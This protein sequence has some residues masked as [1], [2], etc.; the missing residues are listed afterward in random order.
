M[1]KLLERHLRKTA[2]ALIAISFTLSTLMLIA[3]VGIWN[4]S[5]ETTDSAGRRMGFNDPLSMEHYGIILSNFSIQKLLAPAYAY[6]WLLLIMHLVGA[7]L[8]LRYEGL[9]RVPIRVFFALQSL[10]FPVGWL[11]FFYLP[12]V[13][14][15]LLNGTFDQEAMTD[16][17]FIALTAQ[18]I[19]IATSMV[20][21]CASWTASAQATRP[22]LSATPL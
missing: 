19:W 11:G 12:L 22:Q 14:R 10:F 3:D 6:S 4:T 2:L 7:G 9:D 20:I 13:V 15:W 1:R 5:Y 16:A 8:L 18:P 17:P 21:F